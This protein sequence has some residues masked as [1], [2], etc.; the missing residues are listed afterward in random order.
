[1][2]VDSWF[3]LGPVLPVFFGSKKPLLT[4]MD[5]P[6]KII[7]V[8]PSNDSQILMFLQEFQSQLYSML[9]TAMEL[10]KKWFVPSGKLT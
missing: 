10:V 5:H 2:A 3:I 4:V 9:R 8:N 7:G 6:L 1:M